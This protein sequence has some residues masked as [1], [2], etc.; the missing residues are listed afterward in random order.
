[1]EDIMGESFGRYSKYIIRDR[2]IP[3]ARDGFKSV[4]EEYYHSSRDFSIYKTYELFLV[5]CIF[6]DILF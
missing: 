4:K 2:A 5:S 1:M 3:D 6:Y